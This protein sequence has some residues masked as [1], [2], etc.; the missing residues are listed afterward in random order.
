MR[1]MLRSGL[2]EAG[3]RAPPTAGSDLVLRNPTNPT[4]PQRNLT[5]LAAAFADSNLPI[6]VDVIDWARAPDAFR[7]EIERAHAVL[8]DPEKVA[9]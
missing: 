7:R 2:T 5:A 4:A 8:R 1:R 9:P 3:F 6:L